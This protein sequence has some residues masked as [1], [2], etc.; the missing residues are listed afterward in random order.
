MRTELQKRALESAN[1]KLQTLLAD[2]NFTIENYDEAKAEIERLTALKKKDE[3]TR[4]IERYNEKEAKRR[5]TLRKLLAL[6]LPAEDITN[7]G[8]S[9]HATKGKKVA[10]LMEL[11]AEF[12]HIE[13]TYNATEKIY[14]EA[15]VSGERFYL[16]RPVS[17]W[18][19]SDTFPPF[20]TFEAACNFNGIRPEPMNIAKALKNVEKIK[21]ASKKMEKALSEYSALVSSLDGYPLSNMGAVSK[22]QGHY[23]EYR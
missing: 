12:Y 2:P 14:T 4:Q 1:R 3:Q 7:I 23:Y 10:G 16:L 17:K 15:K 11:V 20:E 5:D 13:L 21:A 6:E 19:E 22:Y 9:V 8:G 18:G